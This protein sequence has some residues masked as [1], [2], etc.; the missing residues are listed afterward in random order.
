MNP[1]RQHSAAAERNQGPILTVLQRVLPATGLALE[2]ASGTGQHAAHFATGLPGWRWQP[3]DAEPQALTSISAWCEG[4]PNVLPPLPLDVLAPQWPGVPAQVD[5][6]FCA[7]MLHIS[8]WPTCAALMQGAARHLV[9]QGLLLLYGPYLV[10]DEPTAPGNLAF[11]AD[12]RARNSA[13]GLRRLADVLSQAEAA[14]LQ[15]RERVRMP[16]NNLLLVLELIG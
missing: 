14:G 6:L 4:L 2:I 16:A 1:H 11:D 13:W 3:T 12:L 8:P 5:A 15:L 9:P 7:N 10:E